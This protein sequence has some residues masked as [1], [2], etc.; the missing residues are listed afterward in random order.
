MAANRSKNQFG[1]RFIR[2]QE[3]RYYVVDLDLSRHPPFEGL[4]EFFEKHGLLTPVLR[5]HLP[6]EIVRRLHLERHPRDAVIDPIEPDGSRLNAAAQLMNSINT[7]RWDQARIRGESVHVFDA[8]SPAHAP[9]VQTEFRAVPFES[10]DSHRVRLCDRSQGPLYSGNREYAPI[11]Y[12]YWQIFWLA[13]LLRSGLHIYYPLGDQALVP[14]ILAGSFP[15]DAFGEKSHLSFN[16]EASR[17]LG[18]LPRFERHFEAVG[19]FE[20]YA[21]NALQVFARHRDAHGHLPQRYWNQYVRREGEIARKTLS[22]NGLNDADIIAFIGQ[23]CEWWDNARRVGSAKIAEEYK[24]N[25][26]SSIEL[27][28]AATGIDP[29]EVVT[30]VGCRTG[31]F[32]PTLKVIFPDW[33]EEQ[34]GLTI[35]SLNHWADEELAH[36]PSPFPCSK[37]DLHEFCDWLEDRG[38]FQYYWHFRRLVDLDR[39]D[40]PVHRAAS[41]SEVVGFATLCELICNEVMIDRGLTPRGNTLFPKLRQIFTAQGPIDLKPYFVRYKNLASTKNQSMPQRLAQISRIRAGGQYSPVLRAMLAFM[42][43]RNEGT[44]LGLLRFDHPKVLE[45]IRALAT[46]SLMVWKAR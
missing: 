29:S 13:A 20:A 41:T 32:T 46:A 17:E 3:L 4:V 26:G 34:R 8:L 44:H 23:Q 40:D 12:H 7:N 33:A 15:A 2:L 18:A 22:E 35:R 6:P 25:I 10:W 1:K 38:L 45:L 14:E 39:R 9:F 16:L 24:R 42:A 36:L 43:I 5:I 11:F 30:R 37:A 28:R 31:H 21:Y 27:V 19:Y